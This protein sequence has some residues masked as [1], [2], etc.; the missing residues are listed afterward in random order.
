[1]RAGPVG[2]QLAELNRDETKKV[3]DLVPE[4]RRA[5]IRASASREAWWQLLP[6]ELHNREEQREQALSPRLRDATLYVSEAVGTAQLI[7]RGLRSAEAEDRIEAGAAGTN[8]LM[9]SFVDIDEARQA[10]IEGRATEAAERRQAVFAGVRPE[11]EQAI[12][13]YL[14]RVLHEHGEQA[15]EPGTGGEHHTQ[16]TMSIMKETLARHQ[17]EPASLNLNDSRIETIAGNIVRGLPRELAA[18]RERNRH[19]LQLARREQ[20]QEA[21]REEQ[22]L[23]RGASPAG[24]EPT[25]IE[26]TYG[27][28]QGESGNLSLDEEF[29]EQQVSNRFDHTPE[30]LPLISGE[31]DVHQHTNFSTAQHFDPAVEVTKPKEHVRQYTLTR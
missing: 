29:V 5:V 21:L 27:H 22:A 6:P 11:M 8:A 28:Q 23:G 7:E 16:M 3:R 12:G 31:K 13:T 15:F 14:K 1:M 20:E 10:L 4:E 2:V 9:R 24:R 30:I 18:T 19:L 17:I 26:K 25:E